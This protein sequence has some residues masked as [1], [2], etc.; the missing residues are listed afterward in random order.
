MTK[1]I[2][3][4][5]ERQPFILPALCAFILSSISTLTHADEFSSPSLIHSPSD[6]GGVGLMQMPSSR[7]MPEGELGFNI[8]NNADYINYAVTLQVYPWLEATTRYTQVHNMLYSND[9]SFSGD[10]SYTDKSVD[11]K[12]S[13]ID[14]TYWLPQVSVGFRDVSGTGLFDSEFIAANKQFG[15]LDFT[16]GIGWGYIGNRGNLSGDK[17]GSSGDCGRNTGYNGTGGSFDLQRMFTGCS[18]VYGGVEYQTPFEPLVFK[19]EYDGNDYQGDFPVV[20]GGQ[21]MAVD[22]PWNIGIVYTLADWAR[23][24]LSYERGNTFTAG[25]TLGTNLAQLRPI[26]I[27][28]PRPNYHPQPEKSTLSDDEW[29]KLSS[30]IQKN[31]G[32]QH[33][34]LYQDEESKTVTLE[35]VPTKYRDRKESEERVALLIA[36]T[37]LNADTYRVVE[38]SNNQPLTETRINADSF[39]RVEE[40]D[41]PGSSFDDARSTHNPEPTKGP[42]KAQAKDSWQFGLTPS[43]QQS[44]GGSE[45]FYLYA[46]GINANTSYQLSQHFLLSGSLYGN[47]VDNFDQ[48]NYTVPPDGTDLKRVRTLARKYYDRAFRLDNLQ[49][50][51][52]D[53]FGQNVYGQAYAGYL[54]S[55]FAGVGSELL[56]RPLNTNWAIGIDGNYVKQRDPDSIFGLYTDERH[57]DSQT[58]R[59]Y[60]VQTGT[61]TGHA[62]LYWQPKFWSLFDDSLLKISAGKYLTEDKGVT[63]DFSKQ[64]DSGVIAGVF[65]TKTNLSAAEYGEGSFTKGIYISIPLDLMTIKPSVNRANISWLPLTRDGGQKLGRQYELY[66]MTD[67]RSPWYTRKVQ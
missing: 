5:Q 54:E 8:T 61:L 25:I 64:F 38:T 40:N 56:Y 33:I 29:K 55:M 17:Q 42:L 4:N 41:Y 22:S 39:K 16:L 44:F 49:L 48:F 26:W 43:L 34:S 3:R 28:D 30:D 7:M 18:S 65:A 47:I 23:L 66:G 32:Y 13:L 11:A 58:N 2:T 67:A 62:T 37:G 15:P 1:K 53:H 20:N 6:F 57:F 45:N 46:I 14:E 60:R 51:Y 36:N 35:G 50:T 27:D 12:I 52:F 21:T 59:Y 24:R 31:S 19:L 9:E 63:V 10:T